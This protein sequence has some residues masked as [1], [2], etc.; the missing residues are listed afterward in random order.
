M[1]QAQSPRH[2]TRR[3][4]RTRFLLLLTFLLRT[5]PASKESRT[6]RLRVVSSSKW[7]DQ[8]RRV[9]FHS[10]TNSLA[11]LAV[12]L[13]FAVCT[14]S[15]AQNKYDVLARTLQP[16]GSLFY[17]KSPT[18]AFQAEVVLRDGPASVLNFVNQPIRISL[19]LPNKLRIES[20]DPNHPIVLCRDGQ[21]VWVYP[22]ELAERILPAEGPP[23]GPSVRIP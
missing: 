23:S 14:G 10:G 5:L 6:I 18:K 16:F 1:K 4:P 22:R 13:L 11:G 15:E 7:C 17:S 20:L 19:Q 8:C 21:R 12:I 2:R 3:R 9:M